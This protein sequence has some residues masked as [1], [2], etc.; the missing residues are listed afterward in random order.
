VTTMPQRNLSQ[1][2]LQVVFS[3]FLGIVVVAFVGIALNTVYPEPASYETVGAA[4]W[5]QWRIVTGTWLLICA[6]VVMVASMLIRTDAIPVIGNGILLGGVF[7]MIYAVSMSLSATNAWPR[8]AVVAGALV[9]TVA[10]AYWKFAVRRVSPPAAATRQVP[11][12]ATD[13]DVVARIDRLEHR[14]DGIR[15]ALHD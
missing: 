4:A 1:A 10:V 7:T 9:V 14:L 3:F 11:L 2:V 6:T 15:Q 5:D 13:P 12:T 8:L